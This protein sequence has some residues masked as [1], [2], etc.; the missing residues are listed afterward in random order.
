[1]KAIRVTVIT[2][3]IMHTRG[4]FELCFRKLE[5]L[6]AQRIMQVEAQADVAA[7]YVSLCQHGVGN[8]PIESDAH[9]EEDEW[10]DK[11]DAKQV[12]TE[13]RLAMEL[14]SPPLGEWESKYS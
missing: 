7:S 1:M 13:N 8:R 2:N 5:S 9:H 4:K 11:T 12:V 6:L 10:E 14:D 3:K